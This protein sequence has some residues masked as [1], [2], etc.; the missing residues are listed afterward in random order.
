MC[1]CTLFQLYRTASHICHKRCDAS[2]KA[3]DNCMNVNGAD[4]TTCTSCLPNYAFVSDQSCQLPPAFNFTV[5]DRTTN[6]S[7]PFVAFSNAT[8]PADALLGQ[9]SC[10]RLFSLWMWLSQVTRPVLTCGCDCGC[11]CGGPVPSFHHI[12]CTHHSC[13][14]GSVWVSRRGR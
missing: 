4:T 1:L 12:A 2:D 5:K 11:G 14:V 8:Y 13:G 10:R 3:A 6:Y 9:H 7:F